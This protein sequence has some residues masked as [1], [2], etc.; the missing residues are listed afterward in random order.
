MKLFPKNLFNHIMY[1]SF[2]DFV[3]KAIVFFLAV[4]LLRELG[5]AEYGALVYSQSLMM[6]L[7]P[8][9][10]WGSDGLVS[11]KIYTGKSVVVSSLLSGLGFL[12]VLMGTLAFIFGLIFEI[13]AAGLIVI[14]AV[15]LAATN[16]ILAILQAKKRALELSVITVL[17]AGCYSLAA[18]LM[19]QH[20]DSIMENRFLAGAI[21]YAIAFFV[22]L[23]LLKSDLKFSFFR[24]YNIKVV[25]PYVLLF[26]LPL[27][28]HQVAM[29]AKIEIDK[30][31]IWSFLNAEQLAVYSISSQLAMVIGVFL[32]AVNKACTPYLMEALRERRLVLSHIFL[33]SSVA[34]FLA[35]VVFLGFKILPNSLFVLIFGLKGYDYVTVFAILATGYYLLIPYFLI[36]HFAFFCGYFY[37][38]TAGSVIA[39]TLQFAYLLYF[40]KLGLFYVGLSLAINNIFSVLIISFMIVLREHSTTR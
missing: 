34:T 25:V 27:L 31:F 12:S 7:V 30:I 26:G 17:A 4:A 33:L 35:P 6:F 21:C 20:L 5:P 10:L 22:G 3:S 29:V 37:I 8:M 14:A 38:I 23:K 39:A 9:L 28:L 1:I 15:S 19:V 13:R 32:M 36:G 11:R 2:G 40:G 16:A 24:M 18:I